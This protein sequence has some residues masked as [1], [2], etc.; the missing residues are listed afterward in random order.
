MDA[1]LKTDNLW[2]EYRAGQRGGAKVAVRGLNLNVQ[3]GEVFGFLGPNGAGKT[4]T[5]N[6]LLG[7]VTPTRGE[8]H[9]FGVNVREPIA[10]QRIGYLPELTYYYRFLSAEEL[11]RFY[12]RIFGLTPAETERRID[13]LLKLV[14]LESA[15]KRLIKTYSKGMQQRVGLAQAL[16]NDPDLL[17]LDEPTSGLDP[18][19]R[20]KVREIIQ[21]LKEEGKTV[22]F[23]SHELGEVETV[24][25]RVAIVSQGELRVEG[26]VADLVREH[27]ANLEQ[28]FLRIIGYQPSSLS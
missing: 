21:R 13:R 12:A 23:S 18:L 15:R 5:M 6:V 20:M 10:R 17:I 9:L 3:A 2:V 11:L 7:F 27:Q 25:D 4:T 28:I 22:F 1:I 14:E 16:I 26:R 19:G 24:C 8:A